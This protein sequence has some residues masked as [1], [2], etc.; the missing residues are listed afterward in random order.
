MGIH[1]EAGLMSCACHLGWPEV[2]EGPETP[3]FLESCHFKPE[4]PVKLSSHGPDLT[5]TKF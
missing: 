5:P 3:E 4:I 2:F 1:S